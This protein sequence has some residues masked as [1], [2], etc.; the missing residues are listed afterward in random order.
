LFADDHQSSADL[1][2]GHVSH[3]HGVRMETEV[4]DPDTTGRDEW[5]ADLDALYRN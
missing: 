1:S 3:R 2:H 5:L 4:T